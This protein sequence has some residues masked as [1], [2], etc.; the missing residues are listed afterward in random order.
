MYPFRWLSYVSMNSYVILKLKWLILYILQLVFFLY[1]IFEIFFSS[2]YTYCYLS[3]FHCYLLFHCMDIPSFTLSVTDDEHEH[4]LK[5]KNRA[6][7][8]I[9]VLS[10]VQC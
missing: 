2:Y 4:F 6:A 10:S 3:L 7:M 5:K 1:Y 8:N 9:T